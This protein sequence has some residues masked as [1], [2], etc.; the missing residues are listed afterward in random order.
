M[1]KKSNKKSAPVPEI[2]EEEIIE[3]EKLAEEAIEEE[4]EPDVEEEEEDE[5]KEL[6]VEPSLES[7]E[8][9][10]PINPSTGEPVIPVGTPKPISRDDAPT[11]T[12]DSV[13]G[14]DAKLP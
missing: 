5:E 12:Q 14:P 6:V 4:V 10:G 7:V 9:V 11:G 13:P 1:A 3:G 2:T 8:D